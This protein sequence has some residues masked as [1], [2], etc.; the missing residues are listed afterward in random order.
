M[1]AFVRLDPDRPRLDPART[2][3]TPA[4]YA[5]AV[6]NA[7]IRAAAEADAAQVRE[8]AR[9]AFAAEK[10]RGYEQGLAEGQAEIAE[11][12]IA[13]VT[14]SVDYLASA[15]GAVARTVLVCLRKILG[16]FPEEDLVLRAARAALGLVRDE[17][18]VRLCVRPEVEADLRERVG[19]LLSGRG[20]VGAVEIVSD[21]SMARGGCRL[22]TE[23]GVVDASIEQ[24][25]R[26]LE[27][28]IGRGV[29]IAGADRVT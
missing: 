6:D 17:S 23:L 16:E 27:A 28:A 18:R 26:A 11:R 13:L 8:E 29:G 25:F 5:L 2:I 7:G 24:Q 14:R 10:R 20:A 22:E 12:M 9:E 1:A 15:E 19:E 3:L 4:E 21:P